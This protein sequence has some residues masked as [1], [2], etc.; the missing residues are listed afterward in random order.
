MRSLTQHAVVVNWRLLC[1]SHV[2]QGANQAGIVLK[3]FPHPS[4]V[5]EMFLPEKALT[6]EGYPLKDT[7]RQDVNG[8]GAREA[9]HLTA[10]GLPTTQHLQLHRKR[11]REQIYSQL[12]SLVRS[13]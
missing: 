3:R 13:R 2:D 1:T 12:Y 9:P 10:E 11:I 4:R 6:G 8:I 5:P 7:Y